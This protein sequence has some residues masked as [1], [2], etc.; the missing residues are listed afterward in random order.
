MTFSSRFC[1]RWLA[2]MGLVCA[3]ALGYAA[4]FEDNMAQR[5]QA[6]TAC[7]G[8]QG[9]AAADG[10]YP[11]LAGKPAGYLYNQ[12]LNFKEGR[13][14]YGLMTQLV[15][16]LTDAYL[17]EIAQ[18]FSQIEAPYP[19]PQPASTPVGVLDK[20]RQ[21][22][23]QGDAVRQVP[24]CVQCHGQAMTGVLPGT[25]GLLGLPRDY[26]N[27]QLGAWKAGQRQAHAPDCMK[28]VVAKLS[29]ADIFAV[30]SWLA[31][32]A[33]PANA[34]AALERPALPAGGQVVECGA[35]AMVSTTAKAQ[36]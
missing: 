35:A 28:A 13:R 6:C 8:N 31:A 19:K 11:R 21:L 5:T 33:V 4:P 27:A 18:Y 32:Q 1:I 17:L 10:Y 26:V 36:P 15:D 24:A 34:H 7:H 29:D 12:L 9:R 16:P 30:S 3:S 25:P 23:M 20:G 2:A 22:V 14:H